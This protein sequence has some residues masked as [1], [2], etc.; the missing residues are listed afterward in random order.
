MGSPNDGKDYDGFLRAKSN[1]NLY[2]SALAANMAFFSSGCSLSWT[3]PSLPKLMAEDSWLPMTKEEGSWAGSLLMLGGSLGPLISTNFQSRFGC[4]KA[5]QG[6]SLILLL[7]W[8]V[9]GA[10][11][12]KLEIYIGRFL[13]GIAVAVFFNLIPMYMG[14]ISEK[15]LRPAMATLSEVFVS[16][17]YMLEYVIGPYVSYRTL[18]LISGLLPLISFV[19]LLWIPDSPHYLLMKGSSEEAARSFCWLRGFEK[20]TRTEEFDELRNSLQ[21]HENKQGSLIEIVKVPVNRRAFF[22]A[23]GLLFFQQFSGINVVLFYAQPIFMLTGAE[24]SSSVSAMIVGAVQTISACF[25]PLLANKFG[26]KRPLLASAIGMAV[27]QGLLGLYFYCGLKGYDLSFY[28][29]V[30][31]SCLVLYILVYCLGFGPL[32]WAVMGEMFSPQ[33]KSLASS[34]STSF[35]FFLAFLITKFFSNLSDSIGTFAA[36]WLFSGF[37]LLALI[38]VICFVPN[39]RGMSLE[40]IQDLLNEKI[41]LTRQRNSSTKGYLPLPQE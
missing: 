9:L 4:K 13:Q 8:I 37:C 27:A 29:F 20:E 7:G 41:S 14:E 28:S 31:V 30:P 33:V 3:S 21:E 22:I 39:T 35:C 18:A 32:P 19:L 15:N 26:F 36:F 10:A 6:N 25:T 17:G 34:I 5:L 12:S 24:F 38:F 16:G 40:E 23:N 1:I 11:N 2:L